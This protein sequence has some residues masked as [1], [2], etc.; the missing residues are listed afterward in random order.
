M[1]WGVGFLNVST[2]LVAPVS[3]VSISEGGGC[4]AV[5][6]VSVEGGDAWVV[7]GVVGNGCEG[8]VGCS[9]VLMESMRGWGV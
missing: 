2:V 1:V 4:V 8:V 5:L 6:L 3:V 7:V 9:V